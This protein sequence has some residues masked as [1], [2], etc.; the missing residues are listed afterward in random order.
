LEI[1]SLPYDAVA[2]ERFEREGPFIWLWEPTEIECVL[3]AGTPADDIDL[4]LCGA[5]GVPVYRRKGG[6]GAVVLGPG[7]LIITAAYDASRK[8]FA[9]QWIGP[10][11]EAIVRSVERLGVKGAHVR[12]LGDVAVGERKILGS[13]LYANR[14]LALYQGSLLVDPDLSLIP[15]YLPHP[16]REPD[17]RRGRDHLNFVTSLVEQGYDGNIERLKLLLAEELSQI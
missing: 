16:S 6:G 5:S 9:S 8:A 12:G 17:Y 15:I 4:A 14:K 10:I 13:S 7:N 1:T 3:G 2:L 11:A